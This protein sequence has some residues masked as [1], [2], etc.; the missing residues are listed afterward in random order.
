MLFSLVIILSLGFLFGILAKKIHIPHILGYI[1]AGI[2]LGPS[3]LNKLDGYLLIQS[4]LI[5][6]FILMLILTIAGFS[7]DLEGLKSNKFTVVGLSIIPGLMGIISALF[8][9]HIWLGLDI[10]QS[11]IIGVVIGGMAPAIIL[12]QEN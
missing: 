10:I 8:F 2:V 11:A 5:K 9:G 1:L 7:I 4:G 3:V 6:Q 12:Q